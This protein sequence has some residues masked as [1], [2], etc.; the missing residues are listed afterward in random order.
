LPQ[1]V[2][3]EKRQNR[4]VFHLL[5]QGHLNEA[6]LSLVTSWN[7]ITYC[8]STVAPANILLAASRQTSRQYLFPGKSCGAELTRMTGTACQLFKSM[9]TFVDVLARGPDLEGLLQK[10]QSLGILAAMAGFFGRLHATNASVSVAMSAAEEIGRFVK[11]IPAM[12]EQFSN[13]LTET[14]FF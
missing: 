14:P 11:S 7:G 10:P 13:L 8:G 9:T 4:T 5:L 12:P 6:T 2:W 1:V 3:R